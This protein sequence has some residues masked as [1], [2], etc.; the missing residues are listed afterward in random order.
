MYPF[1][2]DLTRM[3]SR[4]RRRQVPR[5]KA[6]CRLVVVVFA[7]LI[8]AVVS[9]GKKKRKRMAPSL[10]NKQ[11]LETIEIVRVDRLLYLSKSS[12]NK[13]LVSEWSSSHLDLSNHSESPADE[14]LS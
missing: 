10:N 3:V 1:R 14:P 9:G 4:L 12:S 13:E 6:Q 11:T 5:A 7:A 8:I 2:L